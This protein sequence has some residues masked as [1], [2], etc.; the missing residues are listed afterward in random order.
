MGFIDTGTI[1]THFRTLVARASWNFQS[2]ILESYRGWHCDS[3]FLVDTF[4]LTFL[5]H[6]SHHGTG[7]SVGTNTVDPPTLLPN[8]I[9]GHYESEAVKTSSGVALLREPR[10]IRDKK[11]TIERTHHGCLSAKPLK[12]F[13]DPVVLPYNRRSTS[14]RRAGASKS[15][16]LK[17]GGKLRGRT[18]CNQAASARRCSP[19]QLPG[20]DRWL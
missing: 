2:F 13:S 16:V 15:S 8:A 1:V 19:H 12:R 17:R 3:F 4:L 18:Y 9:C 20:G 11:K 7:N 14:S 5:K 6:K 10:S